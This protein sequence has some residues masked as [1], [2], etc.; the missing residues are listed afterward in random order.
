M[1]TARVTLRDR[2]LLDRLAQHEPLS[3]SELCLLFFTGA[4]ACRG[5]L[6]KLEQQKLLTRVYPSREWRGGATEALWFLSPHGRQMIGA[7]ARRPPGLSIPDL[8]HRRAAAGFFL[9]LVRG[10]LDTPGEGL[11]RWLG[12]QQ[13]QH[14]T[15]PTVR[16][17]GYGRYLLPDGEIT[18]YLE[19]DRGTETTKR[20]K[21]KLAAYQRALAA[22]RNRDRGNI[23]LVCESRR[24]LASLARCAPAGPPWVWGTTDR[25]RYRLLPAGDQERGFRELP[26]W[27]RQPAHQIA[28]C[29]GRRWREP[30]TKRRRAA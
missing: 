23:L 14:G 21:D 24:R 25:K 13:A 15:G 8:E 26:A 30:A 7:S 5:R 19:I 27:P 17:D 12:E 20:V 9:D 6:L 3:T 16:P 28:D 29:L 2:E 1:L 4:R 18:F 11:Y 10:S 22:D